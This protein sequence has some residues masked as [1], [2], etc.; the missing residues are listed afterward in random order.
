MT[1]AIVD[2]MLTFGETHLLGIGRGEFNFQA[3][4]E[5]HWATDAG[6]FWAH[7]GPITEKDIPRIKE[8]GMVCVGLLNVLLRHAGQRL[9]FLDTKN[10]PDYAN[11]PKWKDPMKD[12][13]WHTPWNE[14]IQFGYG[15][16]DEWMYIYHK[17]NTLKKFDPKGKYPKGTLLFRIY[18][19]YDGGH[20]AI[21]RES[22]DDK[23]LLECTVLHTGGDVLGSGVVTIDETVR[24]QHEMYSRGKH[25]NWDKDKE[26]SFKFYDNEGKPFGY[27]THVLLPKDYL[28]AKDEGARGVINR[29]GGRNKMLREN[30]KF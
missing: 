8:G 7:D 15:G 19:P 30:Y 23:P 13:T 4:E 18:S 26:F 14:G 17:K 2:K 1:E 6:P 28:D 29:N 11:Y 16:S 5:T 22:S 9:P 3:W 25:W 12:S 20:V 10:F 27:Y 24:Q 21:L